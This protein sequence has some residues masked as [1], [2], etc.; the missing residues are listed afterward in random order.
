MIR[1]TGAETRLHD[2]WFVPGAT[3]NFV[4]MSQ[5]DQLGIWDERKGWTWWL[6]WGRKAMWRVVLSDDLRVLAAPH[7]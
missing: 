6:G 7:D 4:S 2:V 3:E 1:G 5:R